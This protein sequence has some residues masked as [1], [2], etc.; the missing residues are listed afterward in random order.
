MARNKYMPDA[1]TETTG[2]NRDQMEN[3]ALDSHFQLHDTD[4]VG[5]SLYFRV[6]SLESSTPN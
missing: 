6:L 1:V 4:P 3:L 5:S 2:I